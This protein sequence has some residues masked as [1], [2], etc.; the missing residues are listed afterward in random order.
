M[1]AL[2]IL[3][4]SLYFVAY[5]LI[6]CIVGGSYNT[7]IYISTF[8]ASNSV[9]TLLMMSIYWYT[10]QIVRNSINM[11]VSFKFDTKGVYGIYGLYCLMF[12][13]Q[14]AYLFAY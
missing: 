1:Q 3:T 14:M 8:T 6:S 2:L 10:I 5:V 13:L 4:L 9:F 12:S 7:Q 11:C